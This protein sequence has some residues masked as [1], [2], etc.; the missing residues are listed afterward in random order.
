MKYVIETARVAQPRKHG[1][2]QRIWMNIG[3]ATHAALRQNIPV[4]MG[5]IDTHA[6]AKR[7]EYSQ[8]L[9][10]SLSFTVSA[11][12]TRSWLLRHEATQQQIAKELNNRNGCSF[13]Q[14]RGWKRQSWHLRPPASYHPTKYNTMQSCWGMSASKNFAKT[15]RRKQLVSWYCFVF[16]TV[17]TSHSTAS[18]LSS[19]PDS[20]L[21]GSCESGSYPQSDWLWWRLTRTPTAAKSVITRTDPSMLRHIDKTSWWLRRDSLQTLSKLVQRNIDRA[22]ASK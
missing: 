9:L 5:K 21:H 10:S 8:Y 22:R 11:C 19:K 4:V 1:T 3:S 13:S 16:S 20:M 18:V 12:C 15:T 14:C 6:T 7:A 2:T 17:S